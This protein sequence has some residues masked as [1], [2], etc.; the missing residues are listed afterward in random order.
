MMSNHLIYCSR[1]IE[2]FV[3]KI[4][5]LSGMLYRFSKNPL[6]IFDLYNYVYTNGRSLM[7]A[8][9]T[10]LT[11]TNLTAVKVVKT[12]LNFHIRYS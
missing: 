10:D 6:Q 7:I 1:I 12:W 8:N 9:H 3:S 4:F 11:T 5:T 2:R